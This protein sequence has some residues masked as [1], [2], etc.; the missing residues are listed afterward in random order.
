MFLVAGRCL[1]GTPYAPDKLLTLVTSAIISELGLSASNAIS[2]PSPISSFGIEQ[3]HFLLKAGDVPTADD[4]V[5]LFIRLAKRGL[6]S[7]VQP[8]DG[9]AGM[10]VRKMALGQLEIKTDGCTHVLEVAFPPLCHPAELLALYEETWGSIREEI[11][12]LGLTLIE[13]GCL[14]N[15][16][17]NYQK[18]PVSAE[19]QSRQQRLMMRPMPQK[20]F[21]VALL[22]TVMAATHVHLPT[23]D[24]SD[25]A[26]LPFLYSYEYLVPLLFSRSHEFR[27][28][29]AQCVRALMYRDSFAD[30]YAATAFPTRIPNSPESHQALV[31]ASE[32]FVRD[33]S[34]IVPRSF[35]TLEFRTA[36][37]Q[38]SA[39]EALQ[40]TALYMSIWQLAQGR[41]LS[42]V[43]AP[44]DHFYRVCELGAAGLDP[45]A[46]IDVAHLWV[47]SQHLPDPWKPYADRVLRRAT[48][49][50]Q[51]AFST[52]IQA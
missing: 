44:R 41:Q 7:Y 25:Y 34:F 24:T 39:E 5:T 33:Y 11:I 2:V 48:L 14:P 13:G 27:G 1:F 46:A 20:Q 45:N 32:S 18:F 10:V 51:T 16:L 38:P 23:T 40:L 49:L 4:I 52:E 21:S 31:D 36:C 28:H 47:M 26:L 35:G 50:T 30:S 37:A 3:E 22:S 8:T 15:E 9:T 43:L 19:A 17:G 12:P 6:G 42:A 29:Q